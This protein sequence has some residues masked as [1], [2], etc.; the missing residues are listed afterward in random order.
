MTIW[1]N[2]QEKCPG[3]TKANLQEIRFAEFVE[4]SL[5]NLTVHYNSF[6]VL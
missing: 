3:K 5:L 6:F 1:E 4:I 2:C